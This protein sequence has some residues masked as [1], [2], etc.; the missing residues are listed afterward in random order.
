[1]EP[2][3]GHVSYLQYTLRN[4]Y[5][6]ERIFGIKFSDPELQL[7]TDADEWRSLNK[8]FGH[9][10]LL[11]MLCVCVCVCVCVRACVCPCHVLVCCDR[12]TYSI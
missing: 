12:I 9:V 6:E 5:S 2:A 8:T 3:F 7:V 4:P 10:C 11:V 1:M